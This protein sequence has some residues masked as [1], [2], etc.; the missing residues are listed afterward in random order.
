MAQ[1]KAAGK[2]GESGPDEDVFGENWV[3]DN[4]DEEG[5][6]EDSSD[7]PKGSSKRAMQ[8]EIKRICG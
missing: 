5:E 6:A 1:E 7:I 2:E 4:D 8:W 3:S